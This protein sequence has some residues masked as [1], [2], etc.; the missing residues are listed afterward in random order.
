MNNKLIFILKTLAIMTVF[1]VPTMIQMLIFD[2][3]YF[4]T[5]FDTTINICNNDAVDRLVMPAILRKIKPETLIVGNSLANELKPEKINEKFSTHSL[6]ASQRGT[7]LF[8][9]QNLLKFD[10][11]INKNL[12]RVIWVLHDN[13]ICNPDPYPDGKA[14]HYQS[15]LYEN[16]I[17]KYLYLFD[18]TLL[19]FTKNKSRTENIYNMNFYDD[20]FFNFYKEYFNDSTFNLPKTI[21]TITDTVPIKDNIKSCL[22]TRI[23]SRIQSIPQDIEIIFI[24]PPVRLR[25]Y[26]HYDI[27]QLLA[28]RKYL[29]EQLSPEKNISFYDFSI[30]DAISLDSTL[31]FDH[32]H[33][34]DDIGDFI[35]DNLNSDG[36]YFV[37]ESNIDEVNNTLI[38]QINELN[39][40]SEDEIKKY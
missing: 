5:K 11:K 14:L 18:P 21:N 29:V 12:K 38:K 27:R 20:D 10:F 7:Q 2:P 4:F 3:G 32:M 6:N 40:L 13:L 33:F 17:I 30:E 34:S 36:K 22:D 15:Y 26:Y 9:Q 37:T 39:I 25:N 35:V 23:I 24:F 8:E 1:F 16:E 19:S 31:F 28:A